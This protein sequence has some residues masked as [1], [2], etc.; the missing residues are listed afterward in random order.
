MGLVSKE[1]DQRMITNDKGDM[2]E[3]QVNERKRRIG[4]G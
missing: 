3:L 1:E 2:L 4:S